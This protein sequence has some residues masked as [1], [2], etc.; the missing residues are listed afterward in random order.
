M[1]EHIKFVLDR[2]SASYTLDQLATMDSGVQYTALDVSAIGV[3]YIL[4]DVLKSVFTFQA[5]SFDYTDISASDIHYYINMDQWPTNLKIN[6]VNAMMYSSEP[7]RL[8]MLA[9]G[10][11]I[12]A[13]KNFVKHDFIRYLALKL[14]NTPNGVDLFNNEQALIQHLNAMGNASFQGDISG[15][16][17]RYDSGNGIGTN[18]EGSNLSTDSEN[19]R[20]TTNDFTSNSNICRELFNQMIFNNRDR[21]MD[22]SF[23]PT[24][25]QAKL[26]FVAGDSISYKFT[27]FPA[28]GQEV[29]TGVNAFGGRSYEIRLVVGTGVNITGPADETI[30]SGV[31]YNKMVT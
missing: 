4:P 5:D 14:F 27:V 11:N 24:S 29:L 28:S 2:F 18:G 9:T 26:P 6:P 10:G 15:T 3:Y 21:F 31:I 13:S 22:I 25:G 23:N 19:K 16:L 12:D 1:P 17:W 30:A 20:Y 8:P 7:P